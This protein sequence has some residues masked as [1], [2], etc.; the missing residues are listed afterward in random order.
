MVSDAVDSRGNALIILSK[1]P[2]G[3]NLQMEVHSLQSLAEILNVAGLRR[4]DEAR[5]CIEGTV[6]RRFYRLLV[7]LVTTEKNVGLF[8]YAATSN[9]GKSTLRTGPVRI[10]P[11]TTTD[12]FWGPGQLGLC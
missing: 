10:C 3:N 7:V 9:K 4:L 6:S 1:S 11:R 2:D 5:A 8:E 12:Q